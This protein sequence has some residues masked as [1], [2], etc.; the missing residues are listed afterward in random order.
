VVV[1]NTTHSHAGAGVNT[2]SINVHL[3]YEPVG[4]RPLLGEPANP[5]LSAAQQAVRR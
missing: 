1:G 5:Y 4:V 3:P 2:A